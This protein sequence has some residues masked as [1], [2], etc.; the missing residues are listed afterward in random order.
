MTNPT[1]NAKDYAKQ[2]TAQ[3]R[4]GEEL[5]KKMAISGHESI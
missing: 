2:S 1:W 5:I 4:W 3:L